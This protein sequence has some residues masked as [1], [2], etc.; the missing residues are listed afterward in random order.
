MAKHEGKCHICGAIGPLTFEHVPPKAAGNEPYGIS[1]DVH[2]YLDNNPD[3]PL[4]TMRRRKLPRGSGGYV[5]CARCNNLTG[6]HYVE[7]YAIWAGQ[8]ERHRRALRDSNSLA[9]PFQIFPARVFKQILAIFAATCRPEMFE[10]NPFLRELVLN[11][12]AQGMPENLRLFCYIV[13]PESQTS[14]HSGVA[15]MVQGT[16]VHTIAEFAYRP[17]GYL[18]TFGGSPV[19]DRGLFDLTFF[20]HHQYNEYRELHLPIP[21]R[22]VESY[23]PADYRNRA[24]WLDAN[25]V[26][27]Q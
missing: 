7:D 14:R 19:P 24:E 22:H 26:K 10:K 13:H 11:R 9:L 3:A 4:S 2:Q 16:T 17:F 12:D 27:G 5:F 21:T 8:G 20:A 25:A 6:A 18:L 23:F 1:L 15:G